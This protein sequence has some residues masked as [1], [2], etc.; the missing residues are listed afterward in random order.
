MAE[1]LR[2]HPFF[3]Q[4]EIVVAA[5]NKAGQGMAALPP[6]ERAIE[7]VK[8]GDRVGSI[9]LSV[10]KL[11]T[12]VTVR[13]WGAIFMLRSLKSPESYFQAAFRVQSP[14][15]FRDPEGNLDLRKPV[16]FVFEF[17]PN[18]A[19]SLVAEYGA[20]LGTAGDTTPS[21]AIGELKIGRAHV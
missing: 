15:A 7:D 1:M 11:M 10:G 4:F 8:K 17:D 14:W 12:G 5:G 6:V 19:L 20:K 9:T 21:Q 3:S 16:C 2:T 18:R 13:E